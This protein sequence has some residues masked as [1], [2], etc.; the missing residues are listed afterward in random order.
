MSSHTF[1]QRYTS[2]TKEPQAR[3][4]LCY[5]LNPRSVV[6]TWVLLPSAICD[7]AAHR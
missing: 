1:G 6:H 2:I 4:F 3:F 7:F 5:G